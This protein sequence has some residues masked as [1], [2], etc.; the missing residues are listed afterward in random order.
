ML[1]E[2]SNY[3]KKK[4]PHHYTSQYNQ[5]MINS[6]GIAGYGSNKLQNQQALELHWYVPFSFKAS[7][8]RPIF[9]MLM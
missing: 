4:K 1:N 5:K 8:S 2:D 3:Q 7:N 6:I 9:H